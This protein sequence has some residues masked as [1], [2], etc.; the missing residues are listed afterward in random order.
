MKVYVA[1]SD[2]FRDLLDDL[3]GAK[4]YVDL[5]YLIWERDQLTAEVT[6]ILLG[7]L[8]AGVEV[9]ILYDWLTCLP[10]HKTELK[11]LARAGAL[12]VP[13]Y[14]RLRQLNYR[15]HMKIAIVDGDVVYSGG[16]NMGQEYVDGGPALRDVARHS[17]PHDRA[18]RGGLPLALREHLV[19]ERPG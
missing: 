11:R 5:M 9:H 10:F 17:R 4:R 6:D 14:R 2:K 1:G 3:R 8:A 12:V 16:M 18:G 7:R 13:C 15:N 19:A